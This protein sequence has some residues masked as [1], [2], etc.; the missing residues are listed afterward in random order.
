MI[1]YHFIYW[2]LTTS[3]RVLRDIKIEGSLKQ[4]IKIHLNIVHLNYEAKVIVYW[5]IGDSPKVDIAISWSGEN[6]REVKVIF[7]F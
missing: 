5:K 1:I 4:G 7:K 2:I 6:E 3:F